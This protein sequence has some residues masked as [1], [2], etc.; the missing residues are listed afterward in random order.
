MEDELV[1][2]KTLLESLQG[3]WLEPHTGVLDADLDEPGVVVDTAQCEVWT[4]LIGQL[5]VDQHQW[6]LLDQLARVDLAEV[7][8]WFRVRAAAPGHFDSISGE[9]V[10]DLL[11]ALLVEVNHWRLVG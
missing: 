5:V 4:P 8:C 11:D 1:G 7:L 10:H 6:L 2:A 9:R 3:L